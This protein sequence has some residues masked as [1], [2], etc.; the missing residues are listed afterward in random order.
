M[1]NL[2]S[3][4]QLVTL[5]IARTLFTHNNTLITAPE[6]IQVKWSRGDAGNS[7]VSNLQVDTFGETFST[8]ET[9]ADRR[10]VPARP[11]VR[12]RTYG[13]YQRLRGAWESW[14]GKRMRERER[15]RG[16]GSEKEK[17]G[18]EKERVSG[19]EPLTKRRYRS[20]LFFAFVYCRNS[21]WRAFSFFLHFFLALERSPL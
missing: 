3:S 6:V 11:R 20:T 14:G 19:T 8:C 12:L 18:R 1:K 13:R 16:E 9:S 7:A 10:S 15:E 21:D 4:P 5:S 2:A 17:G